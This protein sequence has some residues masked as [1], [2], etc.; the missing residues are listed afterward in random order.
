MTSR[1][2]P[3][4]TETFEPPR[5]GPTQR[6]RLH[7]LRAI[8]LLALPPLFLCGSRWA[9]DGTAHHLIEAFGL[10]LILLCI[11]GR[12]LCSLYIGGR[13]CSELVTIGPYSVTRNPLYF[14]SLLGAIGAGLQAGSL[15]IGTLAGLGFVLV[16]H[17]LILREEQFLARQ[18]PQFS[19]YQATTPRWIPSLRR[20]NS[21]SQ[22]SFE[23]ARLFHTLRDS[24]WFLLAWPFF[25]LIEWLHAE[26][27]C[28]TIISIY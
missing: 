13:K 25:E 28:R 6:R 19:E 15:L 12:S 20:W 5:L 4:G 14:F 8:G 18:F 3:M 21:P 10:F 11:A 27:L 16:F 23:P 17:R 22:L 1:I 7:L 26:G 24:S 9:D 2:D